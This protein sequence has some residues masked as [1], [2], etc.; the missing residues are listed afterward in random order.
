MTVS[1]LMLMALIFVGAPIGRAIAARIRSGTELGNAD[2]I[3][4]ALEDV[5]HRLIGTEQRLDD[6]LERLSENEE[7]LDFAERLL[8]RMKSQDQLKPGN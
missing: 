6:A 7:R 5:E 8:T 3:R 2:G 1:F 4:T